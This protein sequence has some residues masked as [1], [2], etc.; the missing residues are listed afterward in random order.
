MTPYNG[1]TADFLKRLATSRQR[2][3]TTEQAQARLTQHGPNAL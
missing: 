3:L 2:A 1:H